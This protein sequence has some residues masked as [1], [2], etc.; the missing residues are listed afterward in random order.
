MKVQFSTPDKM[1]RIATSQLENVSL[2][3]LLESGLVHGSPLAISRAQWPQRLSGVEEGF[4]GELTISAAGEKSWTQ[5]RYKRILVT[6]DFAEGTA[7][8]FGMM[9]PPMKR[10]L[11]RRARPGGTRVAA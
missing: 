4:Y 10:K 9:I 6:T 7:V 8:G 5:P 2:F 3:A 11:K 1:A